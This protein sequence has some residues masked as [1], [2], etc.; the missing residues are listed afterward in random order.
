MPSRFEPCGLNQL[1]SLRYGTLP[2]V[3]PVGGLA[4]TVVDA[5]TPDDAPPSGFVMHSVSA[6]ALREAIQRALHCFFDK[7]RWRQ[8]QHNAM[9]Q[10]F[11]WAQSAEAYLELYRL[12]RESISRSGD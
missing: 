11:S 9:S 2:V 5:D 4:D 10:D 8:L 3:S 12:A 1:Y 6:E 7:G